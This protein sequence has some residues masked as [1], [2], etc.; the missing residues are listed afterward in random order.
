[1]VLPP[2]VVSDLS[3]EARDMLR[4]MKIRVAAFYLT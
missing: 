1:M 2:T 4:S 3:R